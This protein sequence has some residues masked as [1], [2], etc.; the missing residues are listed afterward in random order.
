ML[1]QEWSSIA[2]SIG[3]RRMG[4]L[5][6]LLLWSMAG[7][8]ESE[9]RWSAM[10]RENVRS[11]RP[12]ANDRWTRRAADRSLVQDVFVRLDDTLQIHPFHQLKVCLLDAL[13]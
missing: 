2:E 1:G 4:V 9:K 11:V 6:W 12:F 5:T 13:A 10:S 7:E 8:C 3:L